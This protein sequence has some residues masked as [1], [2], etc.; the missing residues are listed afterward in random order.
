[1]TT[2]RLKRCVHCGSRYCYQ[3]S[4][5]G[6]TEYNDGNYCPGCK[7][8]IVDALKSVPPVAKAAWRAT[9][10]VSVAQLVEIEMARE[11]AQQEHHNSG[12]WP[13]VRR[14]LPGLFDQADPSNHHKQ[15]ILQVLGRTYRY[16]YW[17]KTGMDAGTVWL[18]CECGPVSGDVRGP[19]DIG[20]HWRTPPTFYEPP[21]KRRDNDSRRTQDE[22]QNASRGN[23][24]GA[25]AGE[26]ARWRLSQK[27][28]EE[29]NNAMME[30]NPAVAAYRDFERR[31]LELLEKNQGADSPEEDSL[32]DESDTVW[33]A[34]SYAEQEHVRNI[35]GPYFEPIR[36]WRRKAETNSK[37]AKVLR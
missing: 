6:A 12:E 4:G 19:W 35:H 1:M 27:M 29:E 20:D 32:L 26:L 5:H 2:E 14:V 9:R 30:T 21:Y 10:D 13:I 22:L 24:N 16:E 11:Q 17:T 15:G 3:A 33:D 18:Q 28:E 8:A 7:K 34:L 23:Q 25:V 37:R 36:E 31:L